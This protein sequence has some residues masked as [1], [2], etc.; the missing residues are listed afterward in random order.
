MLGPPGTAMQ[1]VQFR[2]ALVDSYGETIRRA[3]PEVAR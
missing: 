1:S 3:L 2:Q